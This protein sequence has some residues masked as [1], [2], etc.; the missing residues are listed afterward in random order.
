M[1]LIKKCQTWNLARQLLRYLID[2]I[3]KFD[4]VNDLS[5]YSYLSEIISDFCLKI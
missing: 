2:Y 1:L 5:R 4:G 3:L